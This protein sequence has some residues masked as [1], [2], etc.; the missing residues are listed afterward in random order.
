MKI[1]FKVFPTG[2]YHKDF[3]IQVGEFTQ[4]A[5]TYFF[6]R[7]EYGKLTDPY[8]RIKEV[9]SDYLM[10]WAQDVQQLKERQNLFLPVDFS[11]EYVGGFK[12]YCVDY[13]LK[14]MYGYITNI[15]D[16]VI[17]VSET[18][19]YSNLND[20]NIEAI[21]CFD[22]KMHEFVQLLHLS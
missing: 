1:A 15:N 14:V 6:W 3:L 4:Y 16:L 20:K 9:I 8:V 18:E 10:F 17:R 21:T 19:C 5:D 11:D 2:N 13:L 12:V 7:E 22:M